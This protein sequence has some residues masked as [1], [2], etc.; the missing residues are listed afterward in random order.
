MAKLEHETLTPEVID[1]DDRLRS[2]PLSPT[3]PV[4]TTVVSSDFISA[5]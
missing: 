4:M 5:K 1:S 2:A 3:E